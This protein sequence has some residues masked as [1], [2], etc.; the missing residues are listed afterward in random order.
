MVFLLVTQQAGEPPERH[1]LLTWIYL[2]LFCFRP[3]APVC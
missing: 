2:W 1:L 3:A